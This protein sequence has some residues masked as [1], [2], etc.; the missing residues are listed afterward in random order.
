MNRRAEAIAMANYVGDIASVAS[1]MQ[2]A[3]FSPA[4]TSS[5]TL[6]LQGVDTFSIGARPLLTWYFSRPNQGMPAAVPSP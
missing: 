2:S 6:A 1:A 5:L 4:Q 3:P